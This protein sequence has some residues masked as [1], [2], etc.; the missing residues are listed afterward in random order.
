MG[1]D[2]GTSYRAIFAS[3]VIMVKGSQLATNCSLL[4]MPGAG[5]KMRLNPYSNSLYFHTKIFFISVARSIYAK[6]VPISHR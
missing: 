1:V 2:N 3:A 6:I 5:G 4:K